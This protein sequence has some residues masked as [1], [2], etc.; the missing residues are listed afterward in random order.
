MSY[1]VGWVYVESG[2]KPCS[3]IC[4]ADGVTFEHAMNTVARLKRLQEN[5]LCVYVLRSERQPDGS[6]P[7]VETPYLETFVDVFGYQYPEGHT[8]KVIGKG[9]GTP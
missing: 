5:L 8:L 4:D 3:G 6:I 9:D 7:Y 1:S 2:G